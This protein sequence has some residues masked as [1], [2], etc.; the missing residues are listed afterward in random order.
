MKNNAS[1]LAE[2]NTTPDFISKKEED[3][4][5][6]VLFELLY[7]SCK[8]ADGYNRDRSDTLKQFVQKLIDFGHPAVFDTVMMRHKQEEY[9]K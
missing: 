6:L 3:Q 9:K 5:L 1:N 2:S 7:Q 8:F 4:F